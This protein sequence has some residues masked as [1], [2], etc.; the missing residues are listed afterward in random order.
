MKKFLCIG[1]A[2][3][4]AIVLLPSCGKEE[5]QSSQTAKEISDSVDYAI[6]KT[7]VE[8]KKASEKTIKEI[9]KAQNQKISIELEK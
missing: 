6:G 3:L 1:V 9:E 4:A 5:S 8:A 7:Q 2:L